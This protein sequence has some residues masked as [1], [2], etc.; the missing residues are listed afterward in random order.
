MVGDE[1]HRTVVPV[2]LREPHQRVALRDDV[3]VYNTPVLA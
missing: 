1:L 2:A 3:L